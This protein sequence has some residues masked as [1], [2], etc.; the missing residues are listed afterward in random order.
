MLTE[1]K[2]AWHV[3]A[4]CWQHHEAHHSLSTFGG[5]WCH[6]PNISFSAWRGSVFTVDKPCRL[7]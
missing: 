2:W 3:G 1:V 6:H 4:F 7:R 5:H